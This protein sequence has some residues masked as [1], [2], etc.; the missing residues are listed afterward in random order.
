MPTKQE[1]KILVV[2]DERPMAHALDLKLTHEG[3]T[4]TVAYNGEEALKA[5]EETSFDMVML[6]LMMPKLDGFGVLEA[7]KVRNYKWPAI[8]LSNLSQSEDEKRA[9]DLGANKFFVK[10]NTPIMR[11]VDYA[12]E[13]LRG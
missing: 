13:I 5:M 8:V 7:M 11:I 12:K 9:R 10:S 6:D 3:F 2:E 1:K 4:V